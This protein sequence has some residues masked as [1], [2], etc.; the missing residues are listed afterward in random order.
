MI[1][2]I[3]KMK[4]ANDVRWQAVESMW[5]MWLLAFDR[6]MICKRKSQKWGRAKHKPHLALREI[7][8][9]MK[10]GDITSGV[11]ELSTAH[12]INLMHAVFILPI[13]EK[14][15]MNTNLP[16]WNLKGAVHFSGHTGSVT[17]LQFKS[18][19][20]ASTE[21]WRHR[22]SSPPHHRLYYKRIQKHLVMCWT[23]FIL[24]PHLFLLGPLIEYAVLSTDFYIL[25]IP[26]P[27]STL[28]WAV[29]GKVFC[30]ASP[31]GSVQ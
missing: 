16:G 13:W 17:L 8:A 15:A 11:M 12:I 19:S 14:W 7:M 6:L 28:S 22:F 1:C 26:V 25:I 3:S 18:F 29:Y 5:M 20:S 31:C 4:M 27:P 30:S 10:K 2:A 9:R 23:G 24:F 21:L